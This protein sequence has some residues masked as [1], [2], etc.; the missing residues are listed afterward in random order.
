MAFQML[1]LRILD[2]LNPD[3]PTLL[4]TPVL[5]FSHIGSWEVLGLLALIAYVRD[6]KTGR[7]LLATFAL[8][9]AL[10]FP[11]KYALDVPRPSSLYSEIRSI[12][13]DDTS[14]SFPSGHATFAFSYSVVLSALGFA[15]RPALFSIASAIALSRL[16]L[17]LHYPIDVLG[18]AVIG[19]AS[20]LIVQK[21][22][23]ARD[24]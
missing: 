6:R 11:L 7:I 10:V 19:I 12:G 5:L 14:G 20:G 22:F 4:D 15:S 2:A 8:T 18:G 17:G 3:V 23:I 9:A 16:Y 13:S 24:A 1:Q 21:V